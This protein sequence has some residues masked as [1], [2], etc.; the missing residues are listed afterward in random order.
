MGTIEQLVKRI[1]DFQNII[2]AV[3]FVFLILFIIVVYNLISI[4]YLKR[5]N[6]KDHNNQI[7]SIAMN[8]HNIKMLRRYIDE[9][10]TEKPKTRVSNDYKMRLT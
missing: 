6:E 2:Y 1:N 8:K 10:N 5:N 4:N 9:E 3:G 7:L